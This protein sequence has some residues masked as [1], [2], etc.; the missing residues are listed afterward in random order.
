MQLAVARVSAVLKKNH[1]HF[2]FGQ[3]DNKNLNALNTDY[4]YL[5]LAISVHMVDRSSCIVYVVAMYG[6]K[7][8]NEQEEKHFTHGK[9]N[10]DK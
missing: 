4:Y 2:R 9:R 7:R 8:V 6:K 10:Y 5:D 1:A 3:T